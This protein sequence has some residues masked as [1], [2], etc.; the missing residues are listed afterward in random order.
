MIYHF[1]L[2]LEAAT[3]SIFNQTGGR[4]TTYQVE[5]HVLVRL[6]FVI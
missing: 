2:K 5:G 1:A 6:S 4:K 3:F